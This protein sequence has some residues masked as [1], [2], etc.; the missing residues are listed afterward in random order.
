[1]PFRRS[2]SRSASRRRSTS[3]NRR[4]KQVGFRRNV[5]YS[6]RV[7][8]T[9]NNQRNE[10]VIRKMKWAINSGQMNTMS[11]TTG[12]LATNKVYRAND[13]YDPYQTGVGDQP[14]GFDQMM[15][16]FRH[17]CVLG[18]KIVTVW[19]YGVGSSTSRNMTCSIILKDGTTAMSD[20]KDI[21]EHPRVK[22]GQ[23][24]AES[25]K[26]TLVHKYSWRMNG[27]S[28]A[29]DEAG[30][31]GT[32]SASPAD[33]WYYHINSYCTDGGSEDSV[34]TGYIQFTAAFFHA[35]EPPA[36]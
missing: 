23:L 9:V 24:A 14:R 18:S 16:M 31:W 34:F 11:S 20:S 10:C 35:I 6:Q 33:Q 19:S 8:R 5:N 27:V 12:A 17:F 1:M 4:N 15:T 28:D 7:P 36:S 25:D 22:L 30:L 3:R 29:L 2:R 32:S 26:L 13:L 21:V